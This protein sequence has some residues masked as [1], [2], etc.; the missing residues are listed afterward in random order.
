MQ[1]SRENE[2]KNENTHNEDTN[3]LNKHMWIKEGD[4]LM[5]KNHH[6]QHFISTT[7]KNL[8]F[9]NSSQKHIIFIDPK[10][11]ID[12]RYN[13][14]RLEESSTEFLD[15]NL[16]PNKVSGF[17]RQIFQFEDSNGVVFLTIQSS[18]DIL[19]LTTVQFIKINPILGQNEFSAIMLHTRN[20]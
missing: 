15:V 10:L 5:I 8:N 3:N 7:F 9:F 4:M 17:T 2:V 20:C 14:M 6:Y 13:V 18:K 12:N 19:K 16:K 11:K 1:K